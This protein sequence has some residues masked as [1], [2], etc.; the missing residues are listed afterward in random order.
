MWRHSKRVFV[1]T[2][3]LFVI[4]ALVIPAVSPNPAYR[5]VNAQDDTY[6]W[7]L[8]K[9][10]AV[11]YEP[12]HA[13]IGLKLLVPNITIQVNTGT[14]TVSSDYSGTFTDTWVEQDS[15]GRREYPV[16]MKVK[17]TMTGTYSSKE[18]IKGQYTYECDYTVTGRKTGTETMRFAIKGSFLGPGNLAAGSYEITFGPGTG[19]YTTQQGQESFSVK[20]WKARFTA[21]SKMRD[22]GVRFSRIGGLVEVLLPQDAPRGWK[23]AKL[24]MVLPEGTRI[25]TKDDSSCVISWSDMT[26]IVLQSN[27]V[28]TLLSEDRKS[29]RIQ[30]LEGNIWT[31]VKE[32][33]ITGSMDIEMNQAVTSIKGTTLV[34]EETG[35]KSTVKVIEGKVLVT[36]KAT[37]AKQVTLASGQMVSATSSGLGQVTTFDVKAEESRWSQ[38]QNPGTAST[39]V[40]PPSSQTPKTPATSSSTPSPSQPQKT[41]G[42]NKDLSNLDLGWLSCCSRRK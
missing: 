30:L 2:A 37:A 8:N 33:F 25:R 28:I 1:I 20:S 34:C 18:G 36:P 17:W 22:S 24:D 10:M 15:S 9:G 23:S 29:S 31:K 35:S 13:F 12:A 38:V 3:L 27:T 5:E 7:E 40:T 11:D 42:N 16:T 32:M 6:L 41:T 26:T 21:E 19:T 39:T 4:A 14:K